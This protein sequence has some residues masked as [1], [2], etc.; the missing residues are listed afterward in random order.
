M[1]THE[2]CSRTPLELGR[3]RLRKFY[4]IRITHI[5]EGWPSHKDE[6]SGTR[7]ITDTSQGMEGIS[8][9]DERIKEHHATKKRSTQG[10]EEHQE[11]EGG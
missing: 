5:Y 3:V 7:T 10:K 2:L 4:Q 1:V 9:R 11:K 8:T 6:T